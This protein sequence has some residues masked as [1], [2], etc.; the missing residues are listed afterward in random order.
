MLICARAVRRH[1]W[2]RHP[3]GDVSSQPFWHFCFFAPQL[4]T[5]MLKNVSAAARPLSTREIELHTER[6]CAKEWG[7]GGEQKNMWQYVEDAVGQGTTFGGGPAWNWNR[8]CPNRLRRVWVRCSNLGGKT[9]KTEL[10]ADE[11]ANGYWYPAVIGMDQ[12]TQWY[13]LCTAQRA[14]DNSA[15]CWVHVS[16]VFGS[17]LP[18]DAKLGHAAADAPA[19]P[20]GLDDTSGPPSGVFGGSA[21]SG[22]AAPC[23][24]SAASGQPSAASSQ[25]SLDDETRAIVERLAV[26]LCDVLEDL[27]GILSRR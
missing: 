11:E 7:L 5:M 2:H 22:S 12:S 10:T 20:P 27:N 25:P 1:G 24:P 18:F 4:H 13:P 15:P 6:T 14:H 23:Q 21:S 3:T 26:M 16:R 17:A 8:S 9:L 19:G